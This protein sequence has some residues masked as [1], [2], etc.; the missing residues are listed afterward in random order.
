MSSYR[1]TYSSV[2]LKAVRVSVATSTTH[3][4]GSHQPPKS[5]ELDLATIMP[6]LIQHTGLSRQVTG[7]G[8]DEN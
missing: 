2:S 8:S 7:D 1:V 4:F 6:C 5:A 3:G